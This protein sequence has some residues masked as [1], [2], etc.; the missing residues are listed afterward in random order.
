MDYSAPVL[1]ESDEESQKGPS[2]PKVEGSCMYCLGCLCCCFV[3]F[4]IV[5]P[6]ASLRTVP[7]GSVGVVTTFGAVSDAVLPSGMHVVSPFAGV[8]IFSTKVI[9][10]EEPSVVPTKQGLNVNLDIAM[11]YRIVPEKARD[12]FVKLGEDYQ[13]SYLQP[14]LSAAVRG[15]TSG[16]R[17][18][19]LYNSTREQLQT[20]LQTIMQGLLDTHGIVVEKVLLKDVVLPQLLK[21]AIE[22]KTAAEQEAE[23]MVFVLQKERQEAKRKEVE[24]TGIQTFQ[25]IVSKGISAPLLQWKG[26]EATEK[27]AEAKNSKL[28]LMGN[29]KAS[30]PVL[31]SNNE[32]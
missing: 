5:Y 29:S 14:Q 30:L 10:L 20:E 3:I 2:L 9:L 26:I 13:I 1:E 6:L 31:M 32:M 21:T 28:V 19:A 24:A 25:N 7:P 11:L 8:A 12:I 15:V 23:R 22:T 17:A 16:V 4:A 27:L 18:E